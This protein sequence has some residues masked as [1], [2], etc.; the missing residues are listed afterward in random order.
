MKIAIIGHKRIPSNEGGI[1]KGV[2]Q[3]A[4]RM[5][6][7]GHQ[8]T[9]YNRGG[10]N[11]Y[12]KEYDH[13]KKR[14]YRGIRVVTIPT[15]RGPCE[16]P[17]Y[18]LLATLHCIFISR[19]DVISFRA[20]GPCMMVP[21]ARM[22]HI[23]TVASL[24]GLD[25]QREKWG[26]FASWYLRMGE[27]MAAKVADV[28]LVLSH[29]MKQFVDCTYKTNSIVFANGV[30]APTK[31]EPN[32]I[33]DKW[34]LE[35]NSFVLSMGRIVPEKGLQYLIGGFKRCKT[36]KKLVIAGAPYSNFEYYRSLQEMAK[37]DSRI[38]FTGFITG[39]IINELYSNA[40]IFGLPSNLEGMSNA[41]LEAMSFG[42]CCLTSNIPENTEVVGDY[43]VVHTKGSEDDVYEKLQMLLDNP[44]LVAKYKRLAAPY[45]LKNYSWDCV[46]DQMLEIYSGHLVT[47]KDM[48]QTNRKEK[49]I[50]R[51]I[52]SED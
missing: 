12:G 15:F 10:H 33:K 23:R 46:V 30:D 7:R 31:L 49:V 29:G 22:F 43:A 51:N 18:S 44:E 16:V 13:E 38:I 25:S 26:R 21:L 35:K 9:V 14:W 37:E 28:C 5:V 52:H 36:D 20:S 40:Y 47:Y 48:L 45:I 17:L 8:V 50:C 6:E 32:I 24:H 11:S 27:R 34:G 41:L 19:P 42:N 39:D 3:H 1:E 2:E 4:W